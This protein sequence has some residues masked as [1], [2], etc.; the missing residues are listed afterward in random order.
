MPSIRDIKNYV[1]SS[2]ED[3]PSEYIDIIEQKLKS[4]PEDV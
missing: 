2:E 3:I 1:I 4:E